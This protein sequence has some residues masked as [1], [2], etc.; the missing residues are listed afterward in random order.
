MIDLDKKYWVAALCKILLMLSTFIITIFINRG[1]GVY[2]KGNY[3]YII[4]LVEILYVFSSFGVGQTFATYKRKYG[5]EYRN[6]FVFLGGFHAIVTLLV[7]AAIVY[8]FEIEFGFFIVSLTSL[9]VAKIII[10]MIAVVENSI[11]RNVI[12]TILNF[13]YLLVL[14]LLFLGG[15]SSLYAFLC[16]YGFIDVVTIIWLLYSYKM[17]PSVRGIT[18]KEIKPLYKTGFIT[19]VVMLLISV[20]YSLDVVMLKNLSTASQVG[21]FSVGVTFSNMF[22]LIPD[23]FKEVLFGD[24]AKK[25]F[26]K[27]IA[28]NSIKISF[29]ISFFILFLFVLFGKWAINL[30][31]GV[32]FDYSYTLTLILFVGSLSMIFFKILQPIYISFGNQ[33]Q[34]ALF[35][36]MSAIANFFLNIYLIPKYN[37][38]GSAI[39]SAIS[40]T[41]CG[42][43]FLINFKNSK[44]I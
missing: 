20:N 3:S 26:T 15:Y 13:V 43:L 33:N 39:A 37:A 16:C 10:S 23:S 34:A 4:H 35:L 7:G 14:A 8:L 24:S 1:L 44:W 18:I 21:L 38:T 25:S 41:L 31:Y 22:L 19:M 42:F 40:H 32:E 27:E 5:E 2:N 12:L 28:F 17:I 11:K 9:E 29:I 36:G 30:F 6:F